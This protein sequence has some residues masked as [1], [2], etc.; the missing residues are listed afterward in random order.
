M[1][2]TLQQK[3]ALF[4][5]LGMLAAVVLINIAWAQIAAALPRCLSIFH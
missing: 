5:C 2:L 1:N 4:W 3:K